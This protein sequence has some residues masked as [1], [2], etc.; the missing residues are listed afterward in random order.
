[1][2][3]IRTNGNYFVINYMLVSKLPL[4]VISHRM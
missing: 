1:M 3:L 4:K 2:L